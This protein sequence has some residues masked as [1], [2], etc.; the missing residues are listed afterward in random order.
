M[1]LLASKRKKS[2]EDSDL[3]VSKMLL[4][5]LEKD[6]ETEKMKLIKN[7]SSAYDGNVS[8]GPLTGSVT[9]C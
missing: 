6:V 5:D 7:D 4:I 2:S 9:Y 1:S 3:F 8:R